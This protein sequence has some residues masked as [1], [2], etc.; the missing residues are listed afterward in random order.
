MIVSILINTSVKKLNKVYDYLVK[1]E[2]IPKIEIGKRVKVSFGR[3]K[4]RFTEGI[5]VKVNDE[6]YTSEYKLKEI[7]EILD[8]VSYVDETKLKL[9]KWMAYMYFCNVYDVLKLMLPPGT[10][11]INSNKELKAK[12]ETVVRLVK[13]IDEIQ[14]DIEDE[15]IKSAKHQLVLNFLIENEYVTKKDVIEGLGISSSVLNTIEKNGYI[16]FENAIVEDDILDEL[17]IEKDEKKV[18]T[19]EQ[20]IAI[21]EINSAIAKGVHEKFLLFGVTGSRKD[22]SISSNNRKGFRKRKNSNCS[23]A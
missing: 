6:S 22:R 1:E 11:N 16:Y 17:N 23:C 3:G 8:D 18:P 13:S 4:D 5:I 20:K 10:N 9:A 12:T 2:D 7:D 19:D 21:D 15:K 14:S